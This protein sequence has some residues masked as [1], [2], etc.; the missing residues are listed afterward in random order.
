MTLVG[1]GHFFHEHEAFILLLERLF[2]IFQ[3]LELILEFLL[4]QCAFFL[5]WVELRDCSVDILIHSSLNLG[6]KIGTLWVHHRLPGVPVW[7]A[8]GELSHLCLIWQWLQQLNV[9][10]NIHLAARVV[11]TLEI[12]DGLDCGIANFVCIFAKVE[13]YV[14]YWR[15]RISENQFENRDFG[16]EFVF[17]DIEFECCL[18]LKNIVDL[19]VV[20]RWINETSLGLQ[21]TLSSSPDDAHGLWLFNLLEREN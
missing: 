3:L 10:V 7:L 15:L 2:L 16:L 1:F 13:F 18:H 12:K 20:R 21:S 6:K 5:V 11:V 14:A 19:G 4:F 8:L 9:H 17:G